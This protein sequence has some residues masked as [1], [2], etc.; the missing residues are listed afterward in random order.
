[1]D[2]FEEFE[3][4]ARHSAAL[5][6]SSVHYK[7]MYDRISGL[8]KIGV[9]EFDLVTEK[10]IWTDTVYD[11]FE[12]PRNS[13]L[14]R[15]DTLKF[16]NERS[17]KEMERLRSEA[18]TS[19]SGF[20]MDILIRTA[21]GDDRWI[22]LTADIEQENGRSVRIF[23]TKQDITAERVAQQKVQVLQ[24]QLGYLARASAM[25][26][27][28]STLA[29][30]VS[31]PLAT[32]TNYLSASLAI[33]ARE[34]ASPKIVE[35][36]SEALQSTLRAGDIIRQMRAMARKVEVSKETFELEQVVSEALSIVA[37]RYE[38]V[39][40]NCDLGL[41]VPVFGDFFQ[42]Q[43]VFINL[44]SNACDAAVGGECEVTIQSSKDE[45]H[46]AICVLDNGPGIEQ[47]IFPN[48]FEAFATSRPASLGLG[49]SIA[50]TIIEAHGGHIRA[51]N[52]SEGGASICFTLPFQSEDCH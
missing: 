27:M 41:S 17:L 9:W 6:A 38:E 30:K 15:S 10:L 29:H 51:D 28:A 11:L 7:K 42:I 22:R 24:V 1:M 21:S 40:I 18:I 35:C 52:R 2:V 44:I 5:A 16:Y 3:T 50:Q 43:Q 20:A 36:L 31:Q 39:Y 4:D 45:T 32:A 8:A 23:G 37:A 19:G 26:V 47:D 14:Q 49:L 34:P 46:L 48:I 12:I 33:A 25:E 13:V